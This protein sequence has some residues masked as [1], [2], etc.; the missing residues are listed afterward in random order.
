MSLQYRSSRISVAEPLPVTL[1]HQ[2][3]AKI[4]NRFQNDAKTS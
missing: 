1:S 2:N 4:E 3:N